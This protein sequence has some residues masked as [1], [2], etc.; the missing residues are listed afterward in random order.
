VRRLGLPPAVTEDDLLTA[1]SRA[2]RHELLV[3][4]TDATVINGALEDWPGG[5]VAIL[6]PPAAAWSPE[7]LL[8]RCTGSPERVTAGP[9]ALSF[10]VGRIPQRGPRS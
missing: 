2:I 4:P 5:A 9:T 6:V 10:A 8:A 3:V 7:T 1:V